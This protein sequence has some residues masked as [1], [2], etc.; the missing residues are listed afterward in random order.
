VRCRIVPYLDQERHRYAVP[1][2][3]RQH[4]A[5][6]WKARPAHAGPDPQGKQ[7][8]AGSRQTA[9]SWVQPSSSADQ[10]PSRS[11]RVK[12]AVGVAC[13]RFAILDP[14]TVPQGLGA[15][16]KDGGGVAGP[17]RAFPAPRSRPPDGHTRPDHVLPVGREDRLPERGCQR[18][19]P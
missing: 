3:R 4:R 15:Y 12:S 17:P 1:L 16:E 6:P 2:A 19:S 9:S 7:I 13:D 10:Y 14:T 11:R 18:T 5:L 8:K